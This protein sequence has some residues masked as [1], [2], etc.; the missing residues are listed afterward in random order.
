[1]IQKFVRAVRFPVIVI[2]TAFTFTVFAQ[3]AQEI[4]DVP[5]IEKEEEVEQFV[6]QLNEEIRKR[7]QVSNSNADDISDQGYKV[8]SSSTDTGDYLDGQVTHSIVVSANTVML[9]GDAAAPGNNYYYGTD[10]SG[11][12]GWNEGGLGLL[13][14]A[15]AGEY[16]VASADTSETVT[17]TEYTQYKAIYVPVSGAITVKFTATAGA[18]ASTYIRIYVNGVDVGTARYHNGGTTTYTEN[19]SGIEATDIVQLY[20]YR[21]GAPNTDISNFRIYVGEPHI[22]SI[23]DG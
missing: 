22:Y 23:V 6:I 8:K 18:E 7:R 20:A 15:T 14:A 9:D 10:G 4:L 3:N 2:V 5:D 21:T 11:D 13:S 1:M 17:H 16:L 12:K 19:I